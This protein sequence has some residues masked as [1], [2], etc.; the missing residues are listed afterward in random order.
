MTFVVHTTIFMLALLF[1][2]AMPLLLLPAVFNYNHPDGFWGVVYFVLPFI[3]HFAL[4]F[5]YYKRGY[6]LFALPL[7]HFVFPFFLILVMNFIHFVLRAVS[8][9]TEWMLSGTGFAFIYFLPITLITL[10]IS[11]VIRARTQ[12]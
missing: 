10:I 8:G 7:S 6:T 3:T 11:L 12:G 2:W 1:I 4:I 9:S 5:I